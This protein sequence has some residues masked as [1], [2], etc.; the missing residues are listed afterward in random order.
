[1]AVEFEENEPVP[2]FRLITDSSQVNLDSYGISCA[3]RAGMKPE[4]V[5]RA[6]EISKRLE[7][8]KSLWRTNE[9]RLLEIREREE[10]IV[11]EFLHHEGEWLNEDIDKLFSKV[12]KM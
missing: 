1:M 11:D 10:Q 4:I 5:E 8:N 9:R 6:F 7:Q 2:L 3:R 12:M